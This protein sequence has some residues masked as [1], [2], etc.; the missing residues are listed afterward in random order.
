VTASIAGRLGT[1]PLAIH[2]VFMTSASVWYMAPLG[3]AMAAGT[4]VGNHL[5]A[6]LC[7]LAGFVTAQSITLLL[8]VFFFFFFSLSLKTNRNV[9]TV[10]VWCVVRW[11]CDGE[12]RGERHVSNQRMLWSASA[13]AYACASA[14]HSNSPLMNVLF[15]NDV[16]CCGVLPNSGGE[17][18]AL[19]CGVARVLA[20]GVHK[21]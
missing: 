12:A 11:W 19:L 3:L 21:R 8:F 17:W 1:L 14:R 16:M 2:T 9:F 5:G 10:V 6:G 4:L 7:W 13:S 18:P 20:V 15:W